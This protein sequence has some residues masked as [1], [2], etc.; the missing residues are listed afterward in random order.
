M[1]DIQKISDR[2]KAIKSELLSLGD[3]RPGS[4]TK[5]YKNPENKTGGYYQINYMHKMRS[6]SDYV[7]KDFV[8]TM[9]V[10]ISEY[11]KMKSLTNEWIEL[12]IVKSR[13]LMK[14][15]ERQKS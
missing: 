6:R 10:Q 2:I 8:E 1:D 5:Q 14:T 9:E 15:K 11:K 4:L 3:L 7:K 12:G 13:L